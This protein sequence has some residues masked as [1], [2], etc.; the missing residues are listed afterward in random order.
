LAVAANA[1]SAMAAVSTAT[2]WGLSYRSQLA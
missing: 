1:S 2:R